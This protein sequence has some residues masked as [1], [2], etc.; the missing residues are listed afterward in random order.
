MLEKKRRKKKKKRAKWERGPGTGHQVMEH[1]YEPSNPPSLPCRRLWGDMSAGAGHH[2]LSSSGVSRGRSSLEV[3]FRP[4]CPTKAG[5]SRAPQLHKDLYVCTYLHT[6]VGNI[7]PC[8]AAE[9][10]MSNVQLLQAWTL[11]DALACHCSRL[12]KYV[13]LCG[14]LCRTCQH[15]RDITLEPGLQLVDVLWRFL[16][17]SV[18]CPCSRRPA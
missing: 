4:A 3:P 5:V 15:P 2:R 16:E 14:L 11:H 12:P 13:R 18:D 8:P 10:S 6:V 1:T 7:Y 17:P 9:A